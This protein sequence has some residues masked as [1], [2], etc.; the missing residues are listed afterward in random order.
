MASA[1]SDIPYM[2]VPQ[3]S[4]SYPNRARS[5]LSASQSYSSAIRKSWAVYGVCSHLISR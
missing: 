3:P 1:Q 4:F 2:S 5:M